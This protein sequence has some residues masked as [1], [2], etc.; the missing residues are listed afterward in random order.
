[1][2]QEEKYLGS[3]LSKSARHQGTR[4]V[5]GATTQRSAFVSIVVFLAV[6]ASISVHMSSRWRLEILKGS[7]SL[8][9]PQVLCSIIRRRWWKVLR[10]YPEMMHTQHVWLKNLCYWSR[11]T[12]QFLVLVFFSSIILFKLAVGKSCC[13]MLKYYHCGSVVFSS[14]LHQGCSGVCRNSYR[15]NMVCSIITSVC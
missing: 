13:G 14:G 5:N 9:I 4:K 10:K 2:C 6:V 15:E 1:M 11:V 7:C 12:C 3:I 8:G